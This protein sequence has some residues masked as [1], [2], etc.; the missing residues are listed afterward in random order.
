MPRSVVPRWPRVHLRPFYH[1]TN[2]VTDHRHVARYGF[3]TMDF[4]LH[5]CKA[6]Q[7]EALT[8]TAFLRGLPLPGVLQAGIGNDSF[9]NAI[10][11][12][13]RSSRL[14]FGFPALK[15]TTAPSPAQ[16][17]P[18]FLDPWEGTPAYQFLLNNLY[19]IAPP[20][21][22][23]QSLRHIRPSGTERRT[24]RRSYRTG[25]GKVHLWVSC[26]DRFH[27]T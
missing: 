24:G 25:P 12:S 18:T 23:A 2:I 26:S 15:S 14:S 10:A 17:R 1:I 27:G 8:L 9:T 22:I 7:L 20:K 19:V 11:P 6:T 3:F 13:A 16:A 4:L 5:R 21:P